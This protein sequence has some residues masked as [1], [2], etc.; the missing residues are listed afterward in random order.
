MST[1]FRDEELVRWRDDR[2]HLDY[3]M[4]VTI[5]DE[6]LALRAENARLR[7]ALELVLDTVAACH[8]CWNLGAS[9]EDFDLVNAALNPS[10]LPPV[11]KK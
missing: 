3:A 1:G 4:C 2:W 10:D 9:T 6:L 11:R 8:D 7:E 5:I